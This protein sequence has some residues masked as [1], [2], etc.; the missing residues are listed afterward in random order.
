[1]CESDQ[2]SKITA[3]SQKGLMLLSISIVGTSVT[4]EILGER[5]G[6]NVTMAMSTTILL[7]IETQ[8]CSRLLQIAP[9]RRTTLNFK[10]RTGSYCYSG[11]MRMKL[12]GTH[13]L[14]L[15]SPQWQRRI[16]TRDAAITSP[17]PFRSGTYFSAQTAR[18]RFFGE[19]SS[20]S[21]DKKASSIAAPNI[22]I[23]QSPVAESTISQSESNDHSHR[24]RHQD[25]ALDKFTHFVLNSN[26]IPLGSMQEDNWLDILDAIDAWLNIGGGFA[27]DSA[28]RLLERLLNEH[29][30]SFSKKK[31]NLASS[32]SNRSAILANLQ[33]DV[34]NAWIEA[35]HQSEGTSQLAISRAEQALSRLL[36]VLAMVNKSTI[37]SHFPIEEYI[38]IVE[39]YLHSSRYYEEGVNKAGMLLLRLASS[40]QNEKW[41]LSIKDHGALIGP[42]Y[43]KCA[44]E[45]L[46]IGSTTTLVTQL[47]E[48][49]TDLKESRICS[50]MTIPDATDL[51]L[52][53]SNQQSAGNSEK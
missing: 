1:M 9:I 20:S 26:K 30:A 15:L 16:S 43:E 42:I 38:T 46:A 27:V 5:R 36:D 6:I 52:L 29:A 10:Q 24:H 4:L 35:F 45:L 32:Y 33:R 8:Q 12:P 48:L 7:T 28:E 25:V 50:E 37:H 49:M 53:D 34:L 3:I 40:N 11:Y 39:G 44:T 22:D 41:N 31:S 23:S 18:K 19:T 2:W 13:R 47:L 21:L 17:F 14:K 51:V